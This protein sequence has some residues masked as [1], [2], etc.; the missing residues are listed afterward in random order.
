MNS[1]QPLFPLSI[2]P[3]TII[4]MAVFCALLTGSARAERKVTLAWDN[5]TDSATSGY[6]VYAFEENSQETTRLDVGNNNHAE[7]TGLKEGLNYTFYVTAYNPFRVESPPSQPISFSVP[8]PL[9]M[10]QSAP[11]APGRMRF[12]AAPGRSYE[13]Q[14][15]TDLINWSTI[16]QTGVVNKYAWIE[17]QDPRA[18]Y[19]S[20]RFYRLKVH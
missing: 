15:S 6:V 14:A 8:V 3:R 5:S 11:G 2:V 9:Q 17:Y 4:L 12:P 7:I 13:L 18:R 16:W 20:S 10:N 1:R 19:Y